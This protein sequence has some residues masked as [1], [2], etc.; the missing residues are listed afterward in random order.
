MSRGRDVVVQL[1]DTTKLA[2]HLSE[3]LSEEYG[4]EVTTNAWTSG[5][6]WTANGERL[7][8]V[9]TEGVGCRNF[10]ELITDFQGQVVGQRDKIQVYA[11]NGMSTFPVTI[12]VSA[13]RELYTGETENLADFIRTFGDR[14]EDNFDLW[15]SFGKSTP[16]RV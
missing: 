8:V 10:A 4:R 1:L 6:I 16:E 9:N 12:D 3:V 13:L 2:K 15:Y 7:A 11:I 5:V 14:L